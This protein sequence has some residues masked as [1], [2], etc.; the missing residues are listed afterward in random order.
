MDKSYTQIHSYDLIYE[1]KSYTQINS[2]TYDRILL[3]NNKNN[4]K[5]ELNSL[6]TKILQSNKNLTIE[7]IKKKAKIKA[8]IKRKKKRHR[9][10]KSR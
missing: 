4:H 6:E 1:P 9:K 7:Q 2:Y 10:N 5:N 3:F 8:K